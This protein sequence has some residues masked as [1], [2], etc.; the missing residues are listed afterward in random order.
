MFNLFE[1]LAKAATAAVVVPA[2]IVADVI[3]IGGTLADQEKPFTS[4]ALDSLSEDIGQVLGAG[5]AS[6][7]THH[8]KR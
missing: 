3:T 5:P 2:A 4:Q 1:D 6:N 7:D 8:E